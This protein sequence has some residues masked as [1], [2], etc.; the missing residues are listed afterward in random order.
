M[1]KKTP[2][3]SAAQLN[4]AFILEVYLFLSIPEHYSIGYPAILQLS[5]KFI[6]C[7]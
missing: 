7:Q 1:T 3:I 5:E 6:Q 2:I 4:N